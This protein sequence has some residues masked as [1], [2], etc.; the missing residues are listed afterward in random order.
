MRQEPTKRDTKEQLIVSKWLNKM[1]LEH[2]REEE[3]E[4]YWVD[5]F[6]HDLNL[7]IEL[8]G[9]N[10]LVKRDSIRD[11]YLVNTYGIS[12][13]RIKNKT[14][15]PDYRPEFEKEILRIA[16]EHYAEN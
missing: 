9:Q 10:H 7:A 6:I 15:K 1:G 8:D 4:P 11:S 12:M 14:V 2:S 3:F 16:E 13:W 5:I